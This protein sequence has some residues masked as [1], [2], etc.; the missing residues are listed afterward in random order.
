MCSP[1]GAEDGAEVVVGGDVG[2]VHDECGAGQTDQRLL[3]GEDRP[4]AVADAGVLGAAVG[5]M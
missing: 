5:A 2:D 4:D 3:V 1:K